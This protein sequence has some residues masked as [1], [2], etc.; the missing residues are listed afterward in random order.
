[1]D[2]H[3]IEDLEVMLGLVEEEEAVDRKISKVFDPIISHTAWGKN[4][5]VHNPAPYLASEQSLSPDEWDTHH[6][7]QISG[8]GNGGGKRG[9]RKRRQMR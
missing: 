7:T 4:Q 8:S 5:G 3:T 2:H 9:L 1:M 6:F